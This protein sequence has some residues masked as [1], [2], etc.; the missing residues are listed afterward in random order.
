MA[1]ISANQYKKDNKT[2]A[3][4]VKF[5]QSVQDQKKEKEKKPVAA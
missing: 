2:V 3:D 1:L 4:A 5:Y